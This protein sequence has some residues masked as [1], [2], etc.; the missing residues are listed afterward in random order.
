M[1]SRRAAVA[2]WMSFR[3]SAHVPPPHSSRRFG[4]WLFSELFPPERKVRIARLP[5]ARLDSPPR[6]PRSC[7]GSAP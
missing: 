6:P 7:D 1:P 4:L 3:L 5:S 2:A